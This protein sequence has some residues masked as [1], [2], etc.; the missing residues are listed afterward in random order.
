MMLED[1][2][3]FLSHINAPVL[4]SITHNTR[5]TQWQ[6]LTTFLFNIWNENLRS[7]FKSLIKKKIGYK[8]KNTLIFF[9]NDIIPV[10][11]T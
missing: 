1:K 10:F 5:V 4:H 3:S 8:N 2:L 9:C 6:F 7:S 11:Y